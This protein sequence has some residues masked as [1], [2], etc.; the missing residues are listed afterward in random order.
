MNRF[1]RQEAIKLTWEELWLEKITFSMLFKLLQ[2]AQ[3]SRKRLSGLEHDDH[4]GK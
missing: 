3:K 2:S 1:F 4:A